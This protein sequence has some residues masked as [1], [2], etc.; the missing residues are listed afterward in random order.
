MRIAPLGTLAVLMAT[1]AH[2]ATN[3]EKCRAF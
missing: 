2:P 3:M 1:A